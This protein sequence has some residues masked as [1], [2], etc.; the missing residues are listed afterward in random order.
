MADWQA[1]AAIARAAI[2]AAFAAAGEP[3]ATTDTVATAAKFTAAD[4]SQALRTGDLRPRQGA[5]E[6]AVRHDERRARA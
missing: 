2:L 4:G 5:P 1:D 6:H 3:L